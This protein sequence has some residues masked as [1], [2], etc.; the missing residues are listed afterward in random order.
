MVIRARQNIQT[1]LASDSTAQI[2][3]NSV[4]VQTAT[5][6]REPN[7]KEITLMFSVLIRKDISI[8]ILENE[9]VDRCNVY[10][11]LHCN[12]KM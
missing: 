3:S 8:N 2:I 12:H 9:R 5:S 11:V 10:S 6:K 1:K 4:F 7:I